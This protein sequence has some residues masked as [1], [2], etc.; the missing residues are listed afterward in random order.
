MTRLPFIANFLRWRL[1]LFAAMLSRLL[2]EADPTIPPRRI[3]CI[4]C[5]GLGDRL[6][7]L[8]A[9]R[10]VRALYPHAHMCVAWMEGSL[11][12]A[13]VEFDAAVPGAKNNPAALLWH[14]LKGWNI[15]YVNKQG[16]YSVLAEWCA[17][18]SRAS[19][20]IGPRHPADAAGGHSVYSRPYALL[21]PAHTTVVNCR[22]LGRGGDEAPL[23]YPLSL[24]ITLTPRDPAKRIVGVC[25]G[26][27]AGYEFK[28]WPAPK[29]RALLQILAAQPAMVPVLLVEE[30][31]ERSMLSIAAHLPV[32]IVASGSVPQLLRQMAE[33]DL[34]VAN[35]SGAAHAAAA[36]DIPVVAIFGPTDPKLTAPVFRRG[37][38]IRAQCD[39]APCFDGYQ[40]CED[41]RCLEKIEPETVADAVRE[42][43]FP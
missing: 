22:G 3:L 5:G 28:R 30:R 20:R 24:R 32:R 6:M 23:S 11:E 35:D 42:L 17:I 34:I 8:P 2:P 10:R 14:S 39:C 7:A 29:F 9:L 16:V 33:C 15:A 26:S 21:P 4:I 19:V 31:E 40:G 38:I 27:G 41:H 1:R 13:N 43:L 12:P 18:C 37:K 25:P 36:L